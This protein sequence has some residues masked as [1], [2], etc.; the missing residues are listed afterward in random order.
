MDVSVQL[1]FQN[2]YDGLSDREVWQEELRL[3]ER[4]EDLG[5]D[6]IWAV[7]HHFDDYSMCPDNMALMSYLAGKT[8]TLGLGLGAVI[9]PWHDPLRVAENIIQLDHIAQGRTLVGFGRGLAKMEYRGMRI[10][11]N[12]SR[13]RWDEMTPMILRGLHTGV[14]EGDGPFYPQPRVDI[15]PGPAY[16]F[17]GRIFAIAMSPDSEIAAADIGARMMTFVQFPIEMHMP[18]INNYR[19]RYRQVQGKEPGPVIL[20][21]FCYCHEDPAEAERVAREHLARYFLT[22]LKHY[23]FLDDH[24]KDTKGYTAYAAA[25]DMIKEAG[26]ENA[27]AGYVDCNIWGTPDQILEKYEARREIVGPFQTNLSFVYGGLPFEAANKSIDLFAREVLP[28]L[29]KMETPVAAGSR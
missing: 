25:T 8:T 27:A 16:S 5:F 20:T 28:T 11:M 22:V 10:D 23:D 21:D 13:E 15:R 24:F 1:V 19:E 17:D 12:E 6:A 7:E 18:G 29:K 9:V 14:F 3:A 4:V 2:S 26:K